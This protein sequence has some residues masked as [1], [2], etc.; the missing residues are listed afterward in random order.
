MST[1]TFETSQTL[2]NKTQQLDDAC[3]WVESEDGQRAIIASLKQAQ[4]MAAKFSQAQRV[5][6]E[7]LYR[8]VTR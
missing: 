3:R 7:S 8:P 5:T 6:P 1:K 4:A 2:N